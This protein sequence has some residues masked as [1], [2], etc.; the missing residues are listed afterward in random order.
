M[1]GND[2]T[3]K[4]STELAASADMIM[5]NSQLHFASRNEVF[6]DALREYFLE[7]RALDILPPE[8]LWGPE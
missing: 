7:L 5:Q 3:V 6:R 2:I 4:V 8:V 1:A